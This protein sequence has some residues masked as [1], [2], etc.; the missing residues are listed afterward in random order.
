MNRPLFNEKPHFSL[1]ELII[2]ASLL[3]GQSEEEGVIPESKL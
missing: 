3:S 2:M 1:V